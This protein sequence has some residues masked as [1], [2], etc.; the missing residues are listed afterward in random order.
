[1][2]KLNSRFSNSLKLVASNEGVNVYRRQLNQTAIYYLMIGG[3]IKHQGK[4]K[5]VMA[6]FRQYRP[7]FI[8]TRVHTA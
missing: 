3:Q 2:T 4:K 6:K 1:M 8:S 5:H 7:A